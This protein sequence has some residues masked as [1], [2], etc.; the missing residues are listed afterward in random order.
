VAHA[1]CVLPTG[2][3]QLTQ[4]V[5]RL[6]TTMQPTRLRDSSTASRTPACPQLTMHVVAASRNHCIAGSFRSGRSHA[7]GCKTV[8][9]SIQTHRD[10]HSTASQSIAAFTA[11]RIGAATHSSRY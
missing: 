8:R 7:V 3:D 5:L 11:P 4:R 6:L 2:T 1:A 10:D 9:S